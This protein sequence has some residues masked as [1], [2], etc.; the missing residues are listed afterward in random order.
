MTTVGVVMP[1]RDNSVTV[2]AAIESVLS[3]EPS[4]DDVVVVHGPSRDR[5]RSVAEEY[6]VRILDQAGIGLGAARNEGLSALDTDLVA[7]CDGD[8]TWTDRSLAVRVRHLVRSPDC[9]AVTGHYVEARNIG[10]ASLPALTPG[11]LLVRRS[12]LAVVGPFR[13]DLTIGTDSD[14]LVRLRQSARRLDVLEEI[15][16]HKARRNGSLSTDVATYRRELLEV[17]RDFL[18]RERRY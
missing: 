14:W 15:V 8:D 16:L 7:F 6:P 9:G 13:E 5:T 12:V 4:P 18:R 10:G 3:Q 17:A 11:G 2:A 1:V